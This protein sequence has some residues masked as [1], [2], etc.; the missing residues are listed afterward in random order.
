MCCSFLVYLNLN[1]NVRFYNKEREAGYIH[2]DLI[3]ELHASCALL[4]L[5]IQFSISTFVLFCY[6]A[7][8]WFIWYILCNF[9]ISYSQNI[10]ENQIENCSSFGLNSGNIREFKLKFLVTNLTERTSKHQTSSESLLYVQFTPCVHKSLKFT[11]LRKLIVEDCREKKRS[12]VSSSRVSKIYFL[13]AIV[14]SKPTSD[15]WANRGVPKTLL[16]HYQTSKHINVHISTY[17]LS[18]YFPLLLL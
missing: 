18:K 3:S 4:K 12:R 13:A 5:T 6:A 11:L 8:G 1:I 10:S 2:I 7:C 9:V 17:F 16:L 14:V 15:L